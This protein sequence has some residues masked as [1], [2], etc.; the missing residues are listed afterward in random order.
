MKVH[1]AA[2]IGLVFGVT[3]PAAVNAQLPEDLD[4]SVFRK[5]GLLV[6]WLDLAPLISAKRI[7]RLKE[8]IEFAIEL[9]LALVAPKRFWGTKVVAEAAA[10]IKLGYRIG[11]S[12]FFVSDSRS[13]SS[14]EQLFTSLAAL[15]QYLSD[16]IVSPV[17]RIADLEPQGR[18]AV[19]LRISCISLSDL[20]LLANGGSRGES[21]SPIKALFRQFLNLTSFG[22]ATVVIRSRDF[23]LSEVP[24]SD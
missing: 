10:T 12:D 1:F 9:D 6:V 4:Y 22:R 18:F 8:G 15:H 24:S 17:T 5:E 21:M 16:S 20:N 7:E 13:D 11:T 23:S 14:K 3:A 19:E 2:L